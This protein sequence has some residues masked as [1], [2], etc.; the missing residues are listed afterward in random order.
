[1][2]LTIFFWEEITT[3]SLKQA[4][5]SIKEL[6]LNCIHMFAEGPDSGEPGS[7][8]EAIDSVVK[9]TREG[10]LYM[11]L[12]PTWHDQGE[13]DINFIRNYWRICADRYKCKN[14]SR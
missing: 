2:Q 5:A 13:P 10:S 3:D 12:T 8:M 9:W 7:S 6:G 1:M 4:I 11:I 14:Q